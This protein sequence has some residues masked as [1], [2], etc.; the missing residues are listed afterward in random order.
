MLCKSV[1]QRHIPIRVYVFVSLKYKGL[2]GFI[3]VKV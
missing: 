1:L 3:D 2:G